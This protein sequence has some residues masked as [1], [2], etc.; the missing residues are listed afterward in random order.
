MKMKVS[1]VGVFQLLRCAAVMVMA[2]PAGLAA[3]G[4]LAGTN[5]PPRIAMLWS[6]AKGEGKKM[7]KWAR[8]SVIVTSPDDLGLE[9]KR[10]EF[11]D[12]AEAFEPETIPAARKFL[13]Q[14]QER[15]PAT[16]VLVEL[17]FFEADVKSYP[18]DSAWWFRDEK[19]KTVEFW[20]GCRNM[21]VNNPDYLEHVAR[22]IEAVVRATDGK[23]GI[24]LDNLRFEPADKAAWTN[25][26]GQVRARCGDVP[27]LVNSGW[28]SDDLEWIAPF[29][30]GI[31]YE[32]SIAHTEDKNP[33]KFYQR[34]QAHWNL[35][36]EPRLSVNEVFGKRTNAALMRRELARTLV[37]TDAVF[38]YADST[39][40]HHHSWWPEWGAPLGVALQPVAHPSP[41]R[42]ARREFSGGTVLCL[43]ADAKNAEVI[44][45]EGKT[46]ADGEATSNRELT[47]QPGEGAILLNAP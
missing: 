12:L 2:A 18:P 46:R 24:F 27:I 4:E 11:A 23:A 45:L 13:G 10:H 21:A 33:E 6:P 8:Y 47:L 31:M 14:L 30:N 37:Y 20:K 9:W 38:L 39:H 22:R 7:D 5:A 3:T 44:P 29:I 1:L 25:L 19:G 35:L 15:S 34:V 17:Y 28:D 43:P 41:G 40:G 36:R 26:L 32:D 16:T 42:L